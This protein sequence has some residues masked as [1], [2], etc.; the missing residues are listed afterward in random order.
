[1]TNPKNAQFAMPRK[2]NLKSIIDSTHI[3]ALAF[4]LADIKK[5]EIKINN[6]DWIECQNVNGPLYVT[7]WNSSLYKT[8][9]HCIQLRIKDIEGRENTY[10]HQFSLDGTRLSFGVIPRLL[11]MSNI[12]YIV[13][14]FFC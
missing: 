11:L 9:I 13:S 6:N 2:E 14:I 1:M 10:S 5:V 4:S 8:G 7:K 3:R 12:T